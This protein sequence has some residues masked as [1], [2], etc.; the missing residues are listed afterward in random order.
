MSYE[1]ALAV[2]F[3]AWGAGYVLGFQVR[4]VFDAARAV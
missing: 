2:F 4:S 3:F 1:A